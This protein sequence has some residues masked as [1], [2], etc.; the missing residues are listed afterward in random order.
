MFD[1]KNESLTDYEKTLTEIILPLVQTECIDN[2]LIS[3]E[4][5]DY[6]CLATF[7]LTPNDLKSQDSPILNINKIMENIVFMQSHKE[8]GLQIVDILA[9]CIRRAIS[10]RLQFNGWR[11]LPSIIVLRREGAIS[12]TNFSGGIESAHTNLADFVNYFKSCGK[13]MLVPEH[14]N[15]SALLQGY[16]RWSF[17]EAIPRDNKPIKRTTL[18]YF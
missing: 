4:G 17:V 1:A 10:D 18:E 16:M 3:V 12:L 14:I 5:F 11:Y 6:S 8:L 2:P 15:T 9:N 7:F 13:E